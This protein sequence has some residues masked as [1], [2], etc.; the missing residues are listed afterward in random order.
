MNEMTEAGSPTGTGESGAPWLSAR[1]PC[2]YCGRTID[3]DCDRCPECKTSYSV[4]VRRASREIEGDWFYL[5]ARN[6]SNRGVDLRTMLKLI[7]KG[8]LRPDSVIRGPATNQDWM[9][10]AE[11]PVISKHLGNCPHCFGAATADEEFCSTCGRSLDEMPGRLRPGLTSPTAPARFAERERMEEELA[12]ALKTHLLARTAAATATAA[13]TPTIA[14][15]A[16]GR[17]RASFQSG[18]TGSGVDRSSVM[19]SGRQV[20]DR[21]ERQRPKAVVVML[22]TLITLI[23]LALAAIYLPW[24]NVLFWSDA[25]DDGTI[26]SN[27]RRNRHSIQ[28]SLFGGGGGSEAADNGSIEPQDPAEDPKVQNVLYNADQAAERGDYERALA[29]TSSIVRDYPGTVLAE[30]LREKRNG[31]QSQLDQQNARRRGSIVL[32]SA[33]ELLDSGRP[34]EALAELDKLD[35]EA[36]IALEGEASQLKQQIERAVSAANAEERQ[37]ALRAEVLVLLQKASAFEQQK[38]LKEALEVYT[39]IQN[40]YNRVHH[41]EGVDVAGRIANIEK[42]LNQP[43]PKPAPAQDPNRVKAAALWRDIKKLDGQE[44]YEEALAKAEQLKGMASKYRPAELD[45]KIAYLKKRI[46]LKN[47]YDFFG[48]D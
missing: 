25:E 35:S 4:A 7:D 21:R 9:Y 33:R 23:P 29:L 44:K 10:A 19:A 13:P 38:K 48:I 14:P 42:R 47:K 20:R 22:L 18:D 11:S 12:D 8:R 2:V 15:A 6:P 41:P 36:R 3:R 43:A 5:E 32:A 34:K 37:K 39:D 27:V 30:G 26:A 28:S 40:R 17:D 24:E 45:E 16:L 1:M 31:W 46:E